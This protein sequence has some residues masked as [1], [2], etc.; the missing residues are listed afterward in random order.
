MRGVQGRMRE[1]NQSGCRGI[2]PGLILLLLLAAV[3]LPG[4]VPPRT[5][6]GQSLEVSEDLM[7]LGNVYFVAPGRDT[8][9]TVVSRALLTRSVVTANRIVGFVVTPW[10]AE[11]IGA[12]RSS[13]LLAGA[14]RIPVHALRLGHEFGDSQLWSALSGGGRLRQK[15][16]PCISDS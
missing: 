10:E 13:P 8:Q 9:L 5:F 12:D 1:A 6:A 15:P 14:F 16:K 2:F 3:P 11:E 7:D 4:E